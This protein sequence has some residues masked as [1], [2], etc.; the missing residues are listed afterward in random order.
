VE[1]PVVVA[2]GEQYKQLKDGDVVTITAD[3]SQ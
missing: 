1:V 2:G 3:G